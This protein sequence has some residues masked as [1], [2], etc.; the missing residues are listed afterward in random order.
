MDSC[1]E[2]ACQL[3]VSS[4]DTAP[5]L[6]PAEHALDEV[7]QFIGLSVE[8]MHSLSCRIVRDD[9]NGAALAQEEPEAVAVV[10]GIG[11]ALPGQK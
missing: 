1:F 5:I 4:S 8:W 9:R 10:G 7:A 11:G 2:V 6:E 3:V